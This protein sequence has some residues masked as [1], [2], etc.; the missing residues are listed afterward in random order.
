MTDSR[1]SE[2]LMEKLKVGK[3]SFSMKPG[4]RKPVYSWQLCNKP[5]IQAVLRLIRP[6]LLVKA[7]QVD[8]L[9]TLWDAEE[10]LLGKGLSTE[11]ITL[12]QRAADQIKALKYSNTEG[13]ETRRAG[14]L[15]DQGIVH[16]MGNRQPV[17]QVL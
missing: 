5:Q 3:V 2:W 13:V 7:S 11:L 15:R 16:P 9:F 17:D 14:S 12:R 6:F 8:T 4:N 1:P 10:D